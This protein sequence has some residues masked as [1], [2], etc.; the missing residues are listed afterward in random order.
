[1]TVAPVISPKEVHDHEQ[2]GPNGYLPEVAGA[3]GTTGIAIVEIYL[4]H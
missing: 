4:M 2:A 1:M 3:N